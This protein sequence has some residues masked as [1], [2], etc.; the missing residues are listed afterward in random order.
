[1]STLLL[2]GLGHLGG[3]L[4]DGLAREVPAWRLV[5]AS[6]DAVRGRARVNVARL[7]AV[8][9]GHDPRVEFAPLD[10]GDGAAV[11]TVVD[12]VRPDVI[13]STVTRQTWWLRDLLPEPDAASLA[14]ARFGAWLPV[15][16][17]PTLRLMRALRDAG[18]R[19]PVVTAAYPDVVNAVCARLGLAP[20][21]GLGNLDEIEPKVRWL[22]A[23]RLRVAPGALRVTLVAHHALE[24]F[25]FGDRPAARE[26]APPFFLRV[27]CG[28]EDVTQAAGGDALLF[29]PWPLPATPAWHALTAASALRLIRALRS[30]APVRLHA[31][32]PRGLPGGYPVIASRAGV[33]VA[34]IDGVSLD[35]AIALNE[36]AQRWDGIERIEADGT[37]VVSEEDAEVLRHVL[38]YDGARFAPAEAEAR[39]DELVARFREF[40][41]RAGVDVDRLRARML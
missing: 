2:V 31:P 37:V 35:E 28:E 40:A 15:H 18:Y 20:T 13:V 27:A 4:L 6:R 10:I 33:E 14:R 21:C 8:A 41:R 36:R 34:P 26:A 39:A 1:M 25:V 3:Q 19:G 29:A 22:A 23:E 9:L 32:A 38:G 11:A 5:G 17:A 12:R 16:L 7:A 30:D 24:R